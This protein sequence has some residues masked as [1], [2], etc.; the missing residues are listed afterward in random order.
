M[1]AATALLEVFVVAIVLAL[2]VTVSKGTLEMQA[3]AAGVVT[4]IIVL[5][6][7]FVRYC[8]MGKAW[9]FAGA[10]VLGAFGV[11]LRVVVSTQPSLEVGGGLPIGVTALYIALGALVALLN[12]K[13]VLEL[14]RTAPGP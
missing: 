6:L 12:L 1:R 2:L 8:R 9:S 5:S 10:S 7:V 3:L 4:P 11:V 13:S 14:R